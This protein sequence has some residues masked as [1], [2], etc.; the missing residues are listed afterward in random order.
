MFYDVIP[1]LTMSELHLFAALTYHA[2]LSHTK[3]V[4]HHG[5]YVMCK[6]LPVMYEE[7]VCHTP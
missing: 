1:C 7:S 4:T 3:I 6:G 2:L 5:R